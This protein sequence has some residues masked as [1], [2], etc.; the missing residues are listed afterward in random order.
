LN[1][2]AESPNGW[3]YCVFGKVV[4]GMDVVDKI[5]KVATGNAHG[6]QDVPKD[7]VVI[8]KVVVEE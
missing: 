1:F 7:A 4:D 5:K 3:G 6:H 8:E 2:T